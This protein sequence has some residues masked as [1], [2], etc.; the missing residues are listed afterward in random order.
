MQNEPEENGSNDSPFKQTTGSFEKESQE[1]KCIPGRQY[2]G[3]SP[4]TNKNNYLERPRA[5]PRAE[6]SPFFDAKRKN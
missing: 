4:S 1:E 6:M 3:P 5:D 2:I